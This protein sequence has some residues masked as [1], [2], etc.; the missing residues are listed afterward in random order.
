VKAAQ[1]TFLLRTARLKNAFMMQKQKRRG[2]VCKKIILRVLFFSIWLSTAFPLAGLAAWSEAN[3]FPFEKSPKY[4]RVK[5][6]RILLT[7]LD[8]EALYTFIGPLKP[9]SSGFLSL[10]FR[11]EMRALALEEMEAI[12]ETFYCGEEIQ[13][14]LLVYEAIY[15]GWEMADFYIGRKSFIQ[16]KLS[17]THVFLELSIREEDFNFDKLLKEV[18][19]S[20]RLILFQRFGTLFG[21]PEEAI[22]FFKE[23]EQKIDSE[24]KGENDRDFFSIPVYDR[25]KGAFVWAVP[26]G[27]EPRV[28][29]QELLRTAQE[30]LKEYKKRRAQWVD[31][32]HQGASALI[33]EWYRPMASEGAGE[34][35]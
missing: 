23:A 29:E 16:K 12:F 1:V 14:G 20:Q 27:H 34:S 19:Q 31:G 4:L 11:P 35:F 10:R 7:A 30:I 24:K 17:E 22:D 21:L 33:R 25:E 5:A 15:N 6:E 28:A 2:A 26:L 18:D 3:C 9:M 8:S 13:S 32:N